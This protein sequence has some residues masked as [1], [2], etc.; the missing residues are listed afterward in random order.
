MK[1]SKALVSILFGV[2]M[3]LAACGNEDKSEP[4]SLFEPMDAETSSQQEN[5]GE[6]DDQ[7]QAADVEDEVISEQQAYN[8]VI[9]YCK[10]TN[11]GFEGEVNSAGYTEYWDVSTNEN[12]EIVVLYRSYTAAQI[13]YYVDPASGD[14]YVTEFVPGITDEEQKT[15][16]T[17]NIRDYS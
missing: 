4:T 12:G 3:L 10:A 1:K 7:T 11:P 14:T 2:A 15:G 17:F 5:V 13:R 9:N 16:E 6:T 8:A